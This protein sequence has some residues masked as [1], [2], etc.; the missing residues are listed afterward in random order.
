MLFVFKEDV[1]V[2]EIIDFVFIETGM[3]CEFD[4]RDDDEKVETIVIIITSVM[5]KGHGV[6]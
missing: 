5:M 4:K 6:E 1:I 3:E 2:E